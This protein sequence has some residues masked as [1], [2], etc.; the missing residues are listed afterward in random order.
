M[1]TAWSFQPVD[2]KIHPVINVSQLKPYRRSQNEAFP[3]RPNTRP[4][5]LKVFENDDEEYEVE[6]ILGHRMQRKRRGQPL[7]KEYLIKWKGYPTYDATWEP[8][9]HMGSALDILQQYK[10]NQPDLS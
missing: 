7:Q 5:P 6:E 1:R 8:E 10:Q 4:P 3:D 2:M 9:S